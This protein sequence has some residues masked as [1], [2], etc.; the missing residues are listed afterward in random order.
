MEFEF[1]TKRH[2]VQYG[3]ISH[4]LQFRQVFRPGERFSVAH[5]G[6]VV[7]TELDQ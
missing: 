3:G 7:E 1:S 2:L 4:W 5:F 6:G